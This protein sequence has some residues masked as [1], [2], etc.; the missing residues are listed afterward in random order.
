MGSS[1]IFFTKGLGLSGYIFGEFYFSLRGAFVVLMKNF[2]YG[3]LIFIALSVWGSVAHA[4][5]AAGVAAFRDGDFATAYNEW[6]PI[7]ETGGTAAQHNIGFLY[8]EGLGVDINMAEAAKWYLL[9]SKGGNADAQTKMGIFLSQ[10]YGGLV[11]DYTGAAIWFHEA[12]EQNHP[13]A[14]NNLGIFYA[15][16]TG[17]E[18]DNVQALMWLKLA[19]KAGVEQAAKPRDLL[20]SSMS[21]EEI[22]EAELLVEFMKPAITATVGSAASALRHAP[23][24]TQPSMRNVA[25]SPKQPTNAVQLASFQSKL[26]AVEGWEKLRNLHGDLLDRLTYAIA[27]TDMDGQNVF[28]RLYAGPFQTE[29]AAES[30]CDELKA[31]NI[32]CKMTF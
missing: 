21:P 5:F 7:A 20:I 23:A 29:A 4:D 25:I 27:A 10:G 24:P 18:Q 32:Y 22:E 31:R 16:G 11:K 26:A 13:E 28:Y 14:L 15:M 30:L 12:A 2:T 17:V 8:N 1:S 19:L 9:S 6:R 3:I